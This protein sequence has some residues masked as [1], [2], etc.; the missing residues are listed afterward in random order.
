MGRGERP[1]K[2]TD[3][4]ADCRLC[5]HSAAFIAGDGPGA[6]DGTTEAGEGGV[7]HVPTREYRRAHGPRAGAQG[8]DRRRLLKA[9]VQPFQ[10]EVQQLDSIL[11]FVDLHVAGARRPSR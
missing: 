1:P 10:L 5:D 6:K 8:G 3:R 2:R 11:Q 4:R 7:S 9:W